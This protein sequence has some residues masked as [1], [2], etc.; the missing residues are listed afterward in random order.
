MSEEHEQTIV[1]LDEG[2]DNTTNADV[3]MAEDAGEGEKQDYGNS[4]NA[5]NDL[6]F[7]GEETE[8]PTTFL[9]Y[10]ASPIVTLVVGKEEQTSL[11]AH[12]ALLC[13]S[14]YFKE[15]C[16]KFEEGAVSTTALISHTATT[17]LPCLSEFAP[18]HAESSSLTTTSQPFPASSN[19]STPA[20][21]S[22]RKSPAPAIS[23][24]TP[25]FPP[26]TTP[27]QSSSSTPASTP[28]PRS[29]RSAPYVPSRAQRS[30]ASTP[31]SNGRLCLR[32]MRIST[33]TRTIRWSGR[34][35]RILC[36]QRRRTSSR[37]CV[38]SFRSSVTMF[39]VS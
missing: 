19:T 9:S 38:W 4:V 6:P 31:P 32:D 14:P 22:P 10:L 16:D 8:Q 27:A 29:S 24:S 37:P 30:T 3:E 35:G 34:R 21:T 26:S 28:S 12:Q 5:N 2:D 15:I 25:P 33:R 23:N 13:K 1:N 7:A 20:N 36:G 18:S 11:S 17:K 39:S